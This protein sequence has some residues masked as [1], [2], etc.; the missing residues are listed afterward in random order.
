MKQILAHRDRPSFSV[1]SQLGMFPAQAGFDA[2]EVF[3][4][5]PT[6]SPGGYWQSLGL[7]VLHSSGS[8][9]LADNAGR[10]TRPQMRS[11]T[12]EELR[13]TLARSDGGIV[14]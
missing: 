8:H 2:V 10:H 3:G 14:P 7:P 9:F 12:F 1:S 5:T 6:S 11:A 13:S 4:L